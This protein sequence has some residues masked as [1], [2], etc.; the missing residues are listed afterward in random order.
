MPSFV[1]SGAAGSS[2]LPRWDR[3]DSRA[4]IQLARQIYFSYLSDTPGGQEPIGAVVDLS[5]ASGRV[6]FD[7]PVLLPEE[8][9]LALDLIRGRSSGRV[10]SR[11]KG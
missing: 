7:Q 1:I 4:L 6:V 8:E 9:F 2:Y 5:H 10:R 11:W 3:V